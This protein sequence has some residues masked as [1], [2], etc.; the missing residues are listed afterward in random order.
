LTATK[1]DAAL[2]A[3]LAEDWRDYLNRHPEFASTQGERGADDRWTDPSLAAA[4]A[5]AAHQRDVLAKLESFERS[6]LS[7]LGQTN[8]DL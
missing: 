5:E 7:G 6:A 8:L 2:D 1:A 4:D 3:F